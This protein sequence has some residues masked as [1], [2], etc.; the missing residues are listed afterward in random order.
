M[1]NFRKHITLLLLLVVLLGSVR[2]PMVYMEFALNKDY[3]TNVLC[4][5][6]EKPI[7]VCGGSCYL[8][9][10]LENEQSKK[11]TPERSGKRVALALYFERIRSVF[12][13]K[14]LSA[15]HCEKPTAVYSFLYSKGIFHPPNA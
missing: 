12:I 7:T 15:P 6:R 10:R 14:S 1:L 3:I 4:I 5:N 2:F 8:K 11:G 13:P 9:K